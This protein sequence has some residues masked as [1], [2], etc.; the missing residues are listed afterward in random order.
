MG[1]RK[2][3]WLAE[4]RKQKITGLSKDSTVAE[5]RA[6]IGKGPAKSSSSKKSKPKTGEQLQAERL[7]RSRA[8]READI[9][10]QAQGQEARERNA[11]EASNTVR[12]AAQQAADRGESS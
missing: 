8:N 12:S 7:E 2:A 4:A 10:E 6:A 9:V 11:M 5:I 1:K 3:D